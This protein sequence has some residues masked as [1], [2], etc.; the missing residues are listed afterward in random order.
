MLVREPARSRELAE[1]A[2]AVG[3]SIDTGALSTDDPGLAA[4]L[5]IS[6]LPPGAAD[7]FAARGLARGPGRAGR[8]LRPVADAAGRRR[9]RAA[10]RQVVQRAAML[11]HQAARQVELMTGRSAPLAAMRAAL[12][13]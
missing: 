12:A 4:E 1:T 2:A 10:V 5:V 6:T 11:L 8:G 9:G 3:V 7:P 13:T